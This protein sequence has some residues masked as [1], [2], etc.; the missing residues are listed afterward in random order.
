L[1][2][3]K[4]IKSF[5]SV[6]A[7]GKRFDSEV[8]RDIDDGSMCVY[9]RMHNRWVRYRWTQGQRELRYV[10]EILGGLGIVTQVYP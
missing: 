4:V 1:S 3:T 7:L 8:F 2:D 6:E 10:G 9:D 5:D